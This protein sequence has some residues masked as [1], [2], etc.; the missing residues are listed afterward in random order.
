[1]FTWKSHASL[2]FHFSQNDWYEIHT[3]WI[4]KWDFQP[5][6]NLMPVW[7]HFVSHVKVLSMQVWISYR[8]FWQKRN[9]ISCDKISLSCKHY[10][11][12]NACTCPS[13]Y[14]VILK[15]SRNET[16]CEQN[17]FSCRF[18]TGIRSFGLWCE[19]TLSK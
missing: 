17:L 7:V 5:K 10:P 2:K 11:K 19:H 3:N 13:K 12:L 1:M 9:F 16:S 6:W 14:Q 15:C 4:P 18:K 8:S